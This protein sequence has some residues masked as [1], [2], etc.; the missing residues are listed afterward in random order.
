MKTIRIA[1]GQGFWGDSIDAPEQL[2]EYGEI[3]YTTTYCSTYDIWQVEDI[4]GGSGT[5]YSGYYMEILVGDTIYFD[6]YVDI[7]GYELWAM[8]IE[9]S[10]T[11]G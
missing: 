5:S 6:A 2:I 3:D 4:Q 9:H 8:T 7:T 11:Y 1:N 10:I